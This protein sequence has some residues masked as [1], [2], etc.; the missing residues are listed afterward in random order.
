MWPI[1]DTYDP[2]H[3]Y[4]P[5]FS[6]RPHPSP[7]PLTVAFPLFGYNSRGFKLDFGTAKGKVVPLNE[8]IETRFFFIPFHRSEYLPVSKPT[9]TIHVHVRFCRGLWGCLCF[10]L[11]VYVELSLTEQ[12]KVRQGNRN[13]SV[14]RFGCIFRN[15]GPPAGA[16]ISRGP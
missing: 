12:R 3:I 7:H 1:W 16:R 14:S 4:S 10:L 9:T 2:F 8:N 15:R 6:V 5:L 13:I 11:N